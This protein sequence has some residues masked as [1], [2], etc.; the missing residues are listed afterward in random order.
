MWDSN[1][2]LEIRNSIHYATRKKSKKE[3]THQPR[4]SIE[5]LVKLRLAFLVWVAIVPLWHLCIYSVVSSH[6]GI[7]LASSSQCFCLISQIASVGFQASAWFHGAFRENSSRFNMA[8]REMHLSQTSPLHHPL[9]PSI[10]VWDT[11]WRASLLTYPYIHCNT[12]MFAVSA[13]FQGEF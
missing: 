8:G 12:Y 10:H 4:L 7:K 2:V 6:L 9:D 5:M 13:S 11:A 3:G 1:N